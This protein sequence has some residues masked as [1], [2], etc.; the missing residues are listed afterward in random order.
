MRYLLVA[1]DK[2]RGIGAENDLLW[3]RDLKADLKHMKQLTM[4]HA[5]IMGRKTYESIGRHLPGRQNIVISRTMPATEGIV[6]VSS[7]GEAYE[8]VDRE[9]SFIFGGARVYEEALPYVERIYATEVQAEFPQA[10]VFFPSID[11]DTWHEVSREHYKADG[12][13]KYPYD[14]VVYES[15]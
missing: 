4:G 10:Q 5:L 11:M 12:D 3:K 1:Y 8:A 6:V 7:L 13:N 15:V 9:H 14:F 2:N